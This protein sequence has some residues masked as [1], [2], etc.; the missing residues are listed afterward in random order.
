MEL[1]A[2]PAKEGRTLG[3]WLRSLSLQLIHVAAADIGSPSKIDE[4]DAPAVLVISSSGE[5]RTLQRTGTYHQ[6]QAACRHFE[7]ERQ[8]L[9]DLGLCRVHGLPE[10]FAQ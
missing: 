7:A 8:N 1:K 5:E 3:Y 9:G 6:A 10:R 4:T 2:R